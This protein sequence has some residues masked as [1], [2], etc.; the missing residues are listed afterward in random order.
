[1]GILKK[2]CINRI[3]SKLI[4]K[5]VLA[6]LSILVVMPVTA[7]SILYN[8][9]STEHFWGIYIANCILTIAVY[10]FYENTAL[11]DSLGLIGKKIFSKMIKSKSQQETEAILQEAGEEIRALLT[12]E[13][14]KIIQHTYKDDDLDNV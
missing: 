3:K 11:R 9:F 5:I 14:N 13:T 10:W 8:G 1:M 4:R 7:G 6:W 12:E 2:V